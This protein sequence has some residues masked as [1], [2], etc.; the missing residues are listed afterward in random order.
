MASSIVRL[1]RLA[2]IVICLVVVASFV[3]FAVDQSKT[4]SAHQAN[5][6]LASGGTAS[7][8]PPAKHEDEAHK[9]IDEVAG[10]VTS[11]FTA[12]VSGSHNEWVVRGGK[13]ALALLVYGLGLGFL[14]RTLRLRL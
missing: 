4:A 5:E 2:S 13:L 7:E 3:I 10:E 6:V 11:P 14:A 12:V 9:V 8:Q 1:L